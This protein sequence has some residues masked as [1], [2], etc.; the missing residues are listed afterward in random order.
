MPSG[1]YLRRSWEERFWDKVVMLPDLPG[2]WLWV[3]GKTGSRGSGA[4]GYGNFCYD[5]V[6]HRVHRLAYEILRGDI[7]KDL[8]LDHLCRVRTC[9]NPAHLEPVT[10]AEN[11]RR[12]ERWQLKKTKCQRGHEY[13]YQRKDR[14][15][16]MCTEC[17]RDSRERK[18]RARGACIANGEKTHC[19][20]GHEFT[21]GNTYLFII[22]GLSKGGKVYRGRGCRQCHRE[23]EKN[24]VQA[25]KKQL[26]VLTQS[27]KE[28]A[29]A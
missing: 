16:R 9:V 11:T 17:N 13:T 12:G 20:H 25:V 19:K 18:R 10:G 27:S 8:T 4:G 1:V 29:S 28:P 26:V 22:R 21:P 14:P 24:R 23:R 6:N 2:C 3:G 15:G 7:P 5:G